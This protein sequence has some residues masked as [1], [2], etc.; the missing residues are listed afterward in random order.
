[1]A[2]GGP[3]ASGL[4]KTRPIQRSTELSNIITEGGLIT[5]LCSIFQQAFS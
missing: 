1:M 5:I 2:D 4:L 3:V